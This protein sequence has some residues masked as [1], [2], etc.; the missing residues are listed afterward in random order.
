ME[1]P[2]RCKALRAQIPSL[3]DAGPRS[4]DV[5]SVFKAVG[6]KLGSLDPMRNRASGPHPNESVVAQAAALLGASTIDAA[7]E[8]SE[9]AA[10]LG[11][12]AA[13]ATRVSRLGN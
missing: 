4:Q 11:R 6:S 10:F 9:P 12:A 13:A 7:G 1:S 2:T 5:A 3:Q 8:R